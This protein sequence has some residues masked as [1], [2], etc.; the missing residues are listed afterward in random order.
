MFPPSEIFFFDIMQGSRCNCNKDLWQRLSRPPTDARRSARWHQQSFI[1]Q[2]ELYDPLVS[3]ASRYYVF[4]SSRICRL[5]EL[6]IPLNIYKFI[7]R[8]NGPVLFYRPMCTFERTHIVFYLCIVTSH[9]GCSSLFFFLAS[10][11]PLPL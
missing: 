3:C 10:I 5:A 1:R 6:H 2:T 7:M 11:P 4:I 8:Y 9:S